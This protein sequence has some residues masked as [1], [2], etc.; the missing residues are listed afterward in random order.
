MLTG[1]CED[2]AIVKYFALRKAGIKPEDMR[3]IYTT[4]QGGHVSL[5][6]NGL[7]LDNRTDELKPSSGKEIY[8]FNETWLYFD[9]KSYSNN[10][11]PKWNG[12]IGIFRI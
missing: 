10:L 1:D 4:E 8:S 12:V 5:E 7:I 9:G 2:Y 6:V 3:L 11:L